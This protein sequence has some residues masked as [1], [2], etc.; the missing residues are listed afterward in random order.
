M[1]KVYEAEF[2]IRNLIENNIIKSYCTIKPK[3]SEIP[4]DK[5]D[6]FPAKASVEDWDLFRFDSVLASSCWNANDDIFLSEELWNARASIIHKPLNIEHQ[7]SEIIGHVYDSYILDAQGKLYVGNGCPS[8]LFDLCSSSVIY[9]Y[10]EDEVLQK[11]ISEIIEGIE[12][13]EL[14][15][16]MECL[17]S[18]FD[19]GILDS[20][21]NQKI[22]ERNKS[23][24]HLSKFLRVYGG[25]GVYDNNRI[26]R[27]LRSPNFSAHGVVREPAN[28]RSIIL[29]S[30]ASI[31]KEKVKMTLE[32]KVAQLESEK[33]ELQKQVASTNLNKVEKELADEKVRNEELT[34]E[35]ER[36]SKEVAN[37]KVQK[38]EVN[39]LYNETKASL[40]K[41]QGE[42]GELKNTVEQEKAEA[43]KSKR[44]EALKNAGL[45]ED[46]AKA[47]ADRFEKLDEEQF[48][49][50]VSLYKEKNKTTVTEED[51]VK[52]ASAK[53][54]EVEVEE[55]APLHDEVEEPFSLATAVANI[56]CMKEGK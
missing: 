48:D 52:V 28:Q 36:L 1:I 14:F 40:E 38:D 20:H 9:K 35:N 11:T 23:T 43:K 10:K 19:Y 15:V 29:F 2:S 12:N 46:E 4:I 5:P 30:S 24:A 37:L 6:F 33:A 18:D 42:Y 44:I 45:K 56:L 8:G 32:E 26:G 34:V 53:L 27:V 50:M 55:E 49:E 16:S 51:E 54:Q 47:K 13:R 21:G 39:E 17:F 7:E 31:K 25:N 3:L 22:I 41:V